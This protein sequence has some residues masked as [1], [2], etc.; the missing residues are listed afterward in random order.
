[1]LTT[2]ESIA[3]A[4]LEARPDEAAA[5]VELAFELAAAAETRG[6]PLHAALAFIH[7]RPRA[8]LSAPAFLR[9]C[10]RYKII[11][12]AELDSEPRKELSS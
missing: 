1:M 8:V 2:A 3:A 12:A 11:P 6:I 5:A 10:D 9:W 7:D 4:I